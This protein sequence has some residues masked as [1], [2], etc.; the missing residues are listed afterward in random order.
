MYEV[1]FDDLV[2]DNIMSFLRIPKLPTASRPETLTVRGALDSHVGHGPATFR[3]CI[4]CNIGLGWLF[5]RSC[6]F[7]RTTQD[8]GPI[9]GCRQCVRRERSP[10]MS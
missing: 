1:Y 6:T 5:D 8:S 3:R 4:H 9:W 7:V 10:S 2:W